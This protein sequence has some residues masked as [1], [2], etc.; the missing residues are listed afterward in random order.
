MPLNL[1]TLDDRTYAD[2]VE[3]AR[4]LIARYAPE[5]TNHNASDPGIT[6]VEL[7]AYFTEMLIYRL[8]RITLETKIK[9]LELLTGNDDW[10]SS[11]AEAIDQALRKVAQEINDSRNRAVTTAD[12]EYLA[13][14]C[15]RDDSL[16]PHQRVRR[17]CCVARRDLTRPAPTRDMD[18]PGHVSVVILP[19]KEFEDGSDGSIDL[20]TTFVRRELDA[21]RLLTT[22]LHVIGPCYL[23]VSF[24]AVVRPRRGID[25]ETI[26]DAA[27]ESLNQYFGAF[28]GRGQH[29]RGDG[30]PFGRPIYLSEVYEILGEI[31]GIEEVKQV[32]VLRL[33]PTGDPRGDPATALG[34]QVGVRSRLGQDARLGTGV[35]APDRLLRDDASRLTAVSL[36]PYELVKLAIR[37]EELSDEEPLASV[38]R[39]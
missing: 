9:F 2:L 37:L 1:P 6:L 39:D 19:E 8:D 5:W 7:L 17:A 11:S 32:Y 12:Y 22:R 10:D 14:A 36:K 30:W 31:G 28:S 4:T 27:L 18:L 38:I 23:W 34:L 26:R 25:M 33:S 24:G 20:A 13:V 29:R 3:E 21:K 15:T 16:P 35:I